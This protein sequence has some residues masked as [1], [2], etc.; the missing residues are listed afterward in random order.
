MSSSQVY[1]CLH[2]APGLVG[3]LIR[4]HSRGKYSHASLWV[5]GVGVIE[6][7]EGKGVRRLPD[8]QPAKGE[9]IDVFEVAGLTID[10][11]LD[12]WNFASAQV[13]KKYDWSMVF[14]FVSRATKEGHEAG[15]KWFCSELAFASFKQALVELLRDT[16]AWEVSPVLLGKSPLLKFVKT[17][18]Q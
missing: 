7:R 17:I 11:A 5:P 13:G 4:W 10:Q 15:G 6:S 16:V 14:G 1:L 2:R 9:Q 12:V 18:S 3:D 8:L